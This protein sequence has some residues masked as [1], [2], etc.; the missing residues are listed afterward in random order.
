[1][2]LTVNGQSQSQPI[3]IKM[4]PRVKITPEVQQIFTLT[5]Q[6]ENRARNA[7][8]AYKDAR[9]LA[10]KLK[11]KPQSAANDALIKQVEA[12]APAEVAAAGGGGGGGRGGRGG[13]GGGGA[14]AT[15]ADRAAVLAGARAGAAPEPPAPPNLASIGAQMVAAVQGLQ[16]SEM[17]PTAAQLQSCS[18]Q[19][20]A[21]TNL[22]AKWAALKAKVNGPAVPTG[23]GGAK[24]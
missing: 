20:S 6:M 23:R 5:T 7:T 16:G 2:R 21:Y 8:G 4:D 13:R 15:V 19:E 22:M 9:A 11:A 10:D 12:I 3:A 14:A 17:P 18:E 24:Q 1:V